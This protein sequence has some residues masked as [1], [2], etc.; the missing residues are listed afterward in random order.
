MPYVENYTNILKEIGVDYEIIN[1]D[2]FNIEER[3][4]LVYRD[5]KIGHQRGFLD[6]FRYSRFVINC[7]KKNKYDKIIVFGIQLVFFIKRFLINVYSNKFVID[8]RDYNRIIKYF[9]IEKAIYNSAFTVI[10]SFGFKEWLPRS[11]KYIVNH[12]SQVHYIEQLSDVCR[13]LTKKDSININYI[14]TI[15]DYNIN[16]ELIKSLQNNKKIKINFYG[17]GVINKDI[18]NYVKTNKIENVG[19]NGRYN[20]EQEPG[21]YL[22]TDLANVLIPNDSINSLTLLPNRLYNA[23]LYGKPMLAFERTYLSEIIKKFNLGLIVDTFANMEDTIKNYIDNFDFNAYEEGRKQFLETVIN[24]N[25]TFTK[26]I[27]EFVNKQ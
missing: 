23:V 21:L 12:N 26:K 1:W 18:E 24:E 4:E 22:N 10:S 16:I 14:G 17:D 11:N 15:R 13:N 8:I 19:L 25:S 7:L 27:K 9:N 20:R 2:R 6:Y 5:L 3:S